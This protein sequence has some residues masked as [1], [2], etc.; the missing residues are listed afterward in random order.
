MSSSYTSSLP[1]RQHGVVGQLHCN[2]DIR[3]HPRKSHFK[4]FLKQLLGLAITD[5]VLLRNM[6]L[7]QRY[8]ET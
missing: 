2:G 3:K 5:Y 8:F 1:W 4:Y 6:V 7:L